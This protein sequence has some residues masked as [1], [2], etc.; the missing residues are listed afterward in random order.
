MI[1]EIKGETAIWRNIIELDYPN[2]EKKFQMTG[3]CTYGRFHETKKEI[4]ELTGA[5]YYDFEMKF[6]G[7]VITVY[8]VI[9]EDGKG[10]TKFSML[11][12]VDEMLWLS[13]E[14]QRE[15]LEN[16]VHE[17]TLIPP[18]GK[19][20]PDNQ[21]KILWLSGP[22]GAGKSTTAQYLAREKGWVYYEADC[23]GNAVDPFIPLDVAEPSL[24]QM[25]QQP[26]KVSS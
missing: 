5:K 9:N 17:N 18:N 20:Q 11:G 13:P 19:V 2:L 23:F 16:R 21:G 25:S 3:T 1:T 24:A 7:G 4:E 12:E 14:K 10:V 6:M 15:L 22:P 26:I 8:G